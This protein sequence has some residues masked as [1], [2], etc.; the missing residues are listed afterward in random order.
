MT[1]WVSADSWLP[2]SGLIVWVLTEES[3]RLGYYRGGGRWYRIRGT[4]YLSIK[5]IAWAEV[6]VPSPPGDWP[7][8][9]RVPEIKGRMIE[10]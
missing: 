4:V 8:L 9:A 10:L 1:T 7:A 5:V 3:L 6:E 2:P